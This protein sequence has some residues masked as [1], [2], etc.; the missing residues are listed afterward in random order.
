MHI[1]SVSGRRWMDG[2]MGGGQ[3]SLSCR[4]HVVTSSEGKI[5]GVKYTSKTLYKQEEFND[6]IID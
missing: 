4:Q 5:C 6:Y 3:Y 1:S 2:G